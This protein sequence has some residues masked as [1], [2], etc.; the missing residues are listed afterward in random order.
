M[1]SRWMSMYLSVCPD[2]H[3]R[4]RGYFWAI[5]DIVMSYFRFSPNLVCALIL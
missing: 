1:V 4:F 2:E 5:L 3:P